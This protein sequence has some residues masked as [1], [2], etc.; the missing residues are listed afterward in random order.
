MNKIENKYFSIRIGSLKPKHKHNAKRLEDDFELL[1][2]KNT[3]NFEE[4]KYH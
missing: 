4:A 1:A 2:Y 3:E